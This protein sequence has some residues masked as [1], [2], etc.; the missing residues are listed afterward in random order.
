[1]ARIPFLDSLH[2]QGFAQLKIS[3]D[4]GEDDE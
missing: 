3:S 2:D 1:M 4:T